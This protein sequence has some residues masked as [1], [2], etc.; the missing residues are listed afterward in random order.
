MFPKAARIQHSSLFIPSF[1]F[2]ISSLFPFLHLSTFFS[3]SLLFS[4][5]YTCI[6]HIDLHALSAGV[7]VPNSSSQIAMAKVTQE[8]P[9]VLTVHCGSR[10]HKTKGTACLQH[11]CRSCTCSPYS[12]CLLTLQGIFIVHVPLA[13]IKPIIL[14]TA[15]CI[16]LVAIPA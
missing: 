16:S 7:P 3:F 11:M 13:N 5:S 4:P 6:S 14:S 10:S 15:S 12:F 1:N 8:S 9:Q 2:P